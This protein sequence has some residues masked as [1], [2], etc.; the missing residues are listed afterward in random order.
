MAYCKLMAWTDALRD[1]DKAIK[2]DALF[3]KPYIRKGKIHHA[4]KNYH[5]AMTCYK[6]AQMVEPDNSD[7]KH[8][9]LET[10]AAIMQRNQ[11]GD[12]DE[13]EKQRAMEDPDVQAALN[14]PEVNS[15]LLQAQAGDP[16]ILMK[17]YLYFSFLFLLFF[18]FF[19]T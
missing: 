4:M 16:K 3:V 1:C 2:L 17:L 5:K 14:D 8:A 7:L 6:E 10:Q 12:I 9:M 19:F 11:S 18:C 13:S 15:V